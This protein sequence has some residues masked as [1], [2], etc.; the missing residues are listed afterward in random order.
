MTRAT[1][2]QSELDTINLR[3]TQLDSIQKHIQQIKINAEQLQ[4]EQKKQAIDICT[5]AALVYEILLKDHEYY[6]TSNENNTKKEQELNHYI[7]VTE[8]LFSAE[9]GDNRQNALIEFIKTANEISKTKYLGIAM[10]ALGVALVGVGVVIG[11][12]L[13][14]G[15]W[16][17]PAIAASSNIGTMLIEALLAPFANALAV[18][19]NITLGALGG[20][21][22]FAGVSTIVST[23]QEK[24]YNANLGKK[25]SELHNTF[26]SQTPTKNNQATDLTFT[27][28]I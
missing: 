21:S 28:A 22:I 24:R 3:Q 27:L 5:K 11:I 6:G 25:M 16:A 19:L 13:L 10:L 12:C 15:A 17:A 7:T 4:D 9:P 14:T 1:R 26:F 20:F 2:L 8:A 18:T 23:V